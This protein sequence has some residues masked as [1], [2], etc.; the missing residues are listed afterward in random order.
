MAE[1]PQPARH[2]RRS[3]ASVTRSCDHDPARPET[4]PG[5]GALRVWCERRTLAEHDRSDGSTFPPQIV[6]LSPHKELQLVTVPAK[7]QGRRC[8]ARRG[9]GTRVGSGW[10][11]PDGHDVEAPKP[12][13]SVRRLAGADDLGRRIASRPPGVDPQVCPP[14]RKHQDQRDLSRASPPEDVPGSA[15]AGLALEHDQHPQAEQE[16]H[17]E[18]GQQEGRLDDRHM[19]PVEAEQLRGGVE[20]ARERLVWPSGNDNPNQ[21]GYGTQ[22]PQIC[23]ELGGRGE[24]ETAGHEHPQHRSSD[25]DED[26]HR[27][28]ALGQE[29]EQPVTG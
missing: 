26:Q 27:V 13:R 3:A 23:E 7:H 21:C 1:R 11:K 12:S 8:R 16:E 15:L 22:R 25:A 24:P 9:R 4:A 29:L 18:P 6:V 20:G 19:V 2:G 28:R 14:D 17:S 10:S 5:S